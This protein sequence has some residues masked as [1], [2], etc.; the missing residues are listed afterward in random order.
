VLAAAGVGVVWAKAVRGPA[1]K[2]RRKR[3]RV[4]FIE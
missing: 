4:V 3:R 1:A 2:R